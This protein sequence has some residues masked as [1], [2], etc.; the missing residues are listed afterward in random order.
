MGG[1]KSK[2]ATTTLQMPN[3]P[4]FKA[5][6]NE[7]LSG[8]KKGVG[9]YEKIQGA[10]GKVMDANLA[11]TFGM[12]PDEINPPTPLPRGSRPGKGGWPVD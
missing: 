8:M 1:G 10:A 2:P 3:D 6:M 5:I 12:T 11:G 9:N 7:Y 4:T